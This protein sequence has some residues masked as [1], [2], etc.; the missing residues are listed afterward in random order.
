MMTYNEPVGESRAS[1]RGERRIHASSIAHGEYPR[2]AAPAG[3]QLGRRP[4]PVARWRWWSEDRARLTLTTRASGWTGVVARHRAPATWS[5]SRA[6]F[7]EA[8]QA[9]GVGCVL[10]EAEEV[11][12]HGPDGGHRVGRCGASGRRRSS[13]LTAPLGESPPVGVAWRGSPRAPCRGATHS[14][15]VQPVVSRQPKRHRDARCHQR[16]EEP[17]CLNGLLIGTHESGRTHRP[18]PIRV[19]G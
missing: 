19:S 13:P 7:A 5:S 4:N 14:D 11:A 3:S 6:P 15:V 18:E 2:A 10:V 16:V 8:V 9:T 1:R 12:R 17:A